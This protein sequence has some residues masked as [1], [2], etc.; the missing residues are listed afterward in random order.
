MSDICTWVEKECAAGRGT[1][2]R[3]SRNDALKLLLQKT[4]E[5]AVA[6]GKIAALVRQRD[7]LL[8]RLMGG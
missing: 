5:T 8:S 4:E 1:A 2:K 6:K 7:V 3:A